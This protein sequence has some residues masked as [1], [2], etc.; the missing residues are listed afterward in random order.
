MIALHGTGSDDQLSI[1]RG[2]HEGSAGFVYFEVHC[3]MFRCNARCATDCVGL[4]AEYACRHLRL[5][6]A[7]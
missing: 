4:C 2:T 1:R 6:V 3:N 5:G 7:V